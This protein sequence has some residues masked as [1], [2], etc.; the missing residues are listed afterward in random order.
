MITPREQR[1]RENKCDRGILFLMKVLHG[2]LLNQIKNYQIKNC[3]LVALSIF[4]AIFN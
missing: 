1:S 2:E 3:L 4:E